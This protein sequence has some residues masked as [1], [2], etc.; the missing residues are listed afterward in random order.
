MSPIDPARETIGAGAPAPS[1]A[2]AERQQVRELARQF[3]SLLM[4]QMLRDMRRSMV[5][6]NEQGLGADTMTDVFD[7]ELASS[8]GQAGGFG[9]TEALLQAL[10]RQQQDAAGTGGAA[11]AAPARVSFAAPAAEVVPA[12]AAVM[13][14]AAVPVGGPAVDGDLTEPAGVVTSPYGWRSDPFN[15]QVRFHAGLDIR[16][17]YGQDVHAAGT[18]TVAFAGEQN[19]YGLTV[20]IDHGDGL[21]TRYAHLSG[22]LV[23]PGEQVES[24]Q[25]VARSGNSGRSTGP[26]LHFEVRKDGRAV[27]P[28]LF[29]VDQVLL[30]KGGA[31]TAD[32]TAYG[33]DQ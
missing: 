21:Q 2:S 11:T 14:T 26:H 5:P 4:A 3:E 31:G 8:L 32:S 25:V 20:V 15:G 27:D 18:G 7:G 19:G 22:V 16:S 28:A 33:S 6:D 12:A 10:E 1:Q 13:P 29:A 17:A 23:Q 9:L 24:G 30:A